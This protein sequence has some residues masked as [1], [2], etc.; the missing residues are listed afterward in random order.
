MSLS[1]ATKIFIISKVSKKSNSYIKIISNTPLNYNKTFLGKKTIRDESLLKYSFKEVKKEILN[2]KLMAIFKKYLTNLPISS[3]NKFINCYVNNFYQPP[4]EINNV[5]F[6]SYNSS[7]LIWFFSNKEMII[8][9]EEFINETINDIIEKLTECHNIKN[10]LDA[11]K[12]YII[13]FSSLYGN[14]DKINIK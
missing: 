14:F 7:Y 13:K 11:I 5:I 12:E 3:T 6:K 2:K 9:Y 10:E 1:E 4:F 8:I